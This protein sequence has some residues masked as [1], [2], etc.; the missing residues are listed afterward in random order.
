MIRNDVNLRAG[1]CQ[2]PLHRDNSI[3]STTMVSNTTF[4]LEMANS[5]QQQARPWQA[6]FRDHQTYSTGLARLHHCY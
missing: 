4:K 2:S 3:H 1:A 6:N 5:A